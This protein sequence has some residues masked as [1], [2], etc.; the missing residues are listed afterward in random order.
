MSATPIYDELAAALLTNS[1]FTGKP[2]AAK[3]AA[4]VKQP[5]SA[6]TAAPAPRSS[7]EKAPNSSTTAGK[8][9]SGEAPETEAAVKNAAAGK[10][11]PRASRRGRRRR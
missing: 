8:A 5:A 3:P 11:V 9:V 6:T 4:A 1:D 7:P 10:A 2:N